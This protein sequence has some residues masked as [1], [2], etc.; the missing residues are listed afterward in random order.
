MLKMDV[1][2][3]VRVA[4][5]LMKKTREQIPFATSLAINWT[6]ADFQKFQRAYQLRVFEV[7]Q[8]TFV[9][10]S[11]KLKPKAKKRRLYAKVQIEPPGGPKRAD[12]LA[13]FE[14]GGRKAPRGKHLAVPIGVRTTKTGKI[15]KANRPKAF[16]PFTRTG[17]GVLVGKKRTFILERATVPGLYQHYGSKKKPK[18]RLLYAFKKSVPIDNRL[19]FIPHAKKIVRRYWDRNFHKAWKR[20]LRTAR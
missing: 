14:S 16:G 4:D 1:K 13:K 17:R 7:K 5:R 9:E 6:A 20:A 19:R 2:A 3:D 15:S 18:V 8:R 11:V 12:I 10:R